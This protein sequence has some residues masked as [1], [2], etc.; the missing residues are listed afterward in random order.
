MAYARTIQGYERN[1]IVKSS[2]T[3]KWVVDATL[4]VGYCVAVWLDLTGLELHQWIGVGVGLLAGYHLLT[5]MDWVTAV[6]RRL[7]GK[8]SPRAR[9]YYLINALMLGGF[10]SIGVTGLLIS[11]WLN[12]PLG[13]MAMLVAIHKWT[14]YLTLAAVFVKL[15]LHWRWIVNVAGKFVAAPAAQRANAGLPA[16]AQATGGA[17]S[18]GAAPGLPT[19]SYTRRETLKLMGAAA[20][21]TAAVV[22]VTAKAL[23]AQQTS[24][25]GSTSTSAALATVTTMSASPA[26]VS[27]APSTATTMAAAA[28]TATT[29]AAV[30]TVTTTIASAATTSSAASL[31]CIICRRGKHCTYP[32]DCRDYVDTNSNNRCDLGECA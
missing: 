22:G 24:D 28:P 2:P 15:A 30:P 31:A 23:G 11:T 6:T 7:F 20:L 9:L 12:L 25:N 17:V 26:P 1:F 29:V 5:H 13:G 18:G 19:R 10:V 14:A 32:G 4:L 8:T 16:A 21:S 27:L 3:S